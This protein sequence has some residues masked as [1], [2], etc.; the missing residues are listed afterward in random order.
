MKKYEPRSRN[1]IYNDAIGST[2]GVKL[3]VILE[4]LLDIRD[5]LTNLSV[6]KDDAEK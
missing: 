4:T 3:L 5:Q 1:S 2:E 6:Q